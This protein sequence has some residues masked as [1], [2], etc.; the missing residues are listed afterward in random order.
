[1]ADGADVRFRLASPAVPTAATVLEITGDSVRVV[2]GSGPPCTPAGCAPQTLVDAALDWIDDP[3]GLLEE[4]PIAVADLWVSLMATL[5][6]GHCD[7]VVVVHPQDWPRHRVDR[8]LAAA[9]AVA[10]RVEAVSRDRWTG[11]AGDEPKDDHVDDGHVGGG[12]PKPR[13]LPVTALLAA[14]VLVMAGITLAIRSAPGPQD[15]AGVSVVE[16]RMAVRIPAH[17]TVQRVTGGPGSRRLQVSPPQ[18]SGIALHLTSAYA[19][20]TTLAQAAEV[21]NRAITHEPPDVFVDVRSLD[22]V[23][24]RSAVTYREVRPGHIIAWS[25]VLSGSTRISIGCQSPAGRE[26]EIRPACDEAVRS[27]QER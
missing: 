9:N 10:D 25:V 2:P 26:A 3:V 19:P 20:E 5:V 12:R 21:L 1:M 16:G 17:W 13:R 11:E 18:S 4:R 7:S 6:G 15:A 24:G 23:A 8:V 27:A 14:S 22:E